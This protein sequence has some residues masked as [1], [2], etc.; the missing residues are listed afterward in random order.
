MA[1]S[2]QLI[3]HL[4]Y[5]VLLAL[6]A[7]VTTVLIVLIPYRNYALYLKFLGLVLLAYVIS[8]FS[9]KVDWRQVLTATF[10]PHVQWNKDYVLTLIAVFGVTISPYEFFWQSSEEV[11]ELVD[12]KKLDREGSS[13]PQTSRAALR[14]LRNDTVFGMFFSNAITFFVIITAAATLHAHGYTDVQS[15][16]QAAQVLKPLAG[17]FTASLFTVGIIS[18][19]LLAIPV[20][21]GSSAYAVGGAFDWSRTLSKPFWQEWRFYGII[22]AS[23]MVGLLVNALHV[24]PFKLLYYS[25]VLNGVISPVLLFMVTQI[26]SNRRIMKQ[27][28]S[29]RF[30]VV[31][32][33]SL[34]GFM[35]VAL[36]AFV[37]LSRT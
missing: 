23:C 11:E 30:S 7:F 8:A 21:A 29:P 2:T 15:A 22:V 17:G 5:Y 37:V 9:V 36:I 10:V 6:T 1:E 27:F 14:F 24:P 33:W 35:T 12:E 16:A 4:P 18:A 28:T 13:R 19:G 25:A 20:M 31:M 3:W 26:A 34:C 32:G